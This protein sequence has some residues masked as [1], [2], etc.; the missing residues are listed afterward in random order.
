M[1]SK[2]EKDSNAKEDWTNDEI[3]LINDM[4][5]A[6]P[7]LRN[8]YHTDYTIRGMKEIAYT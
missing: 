5:K 6:N 7:Y 4:L 3:S 1:V 2:K 8:V